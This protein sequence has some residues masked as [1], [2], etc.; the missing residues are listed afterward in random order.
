MLRQT[1]H[2]TTTLLLSHEQL[3]PTMHVQRTLAM[4]RDRTHNT[5]SWAGHKVVHA[6]QQHLGQG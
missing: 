5:K 3:V 6:K 1:T 2:F 4:P